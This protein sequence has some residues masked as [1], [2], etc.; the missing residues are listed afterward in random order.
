[1]VRSRYLACAVAALAVALTVAACGGGSDSTSSTTASAATSTDTSTS[2]ATT[3]EPTAYLA[4]KIA[5]APGGGGVSVA[6]IAA[7]GAADRAGV[8]P[9][10]VIVAMDG[11]TTKTV[12]ALV[13]QLGKRKPGDMVELTIERGNKRLKVT[14]TLDERPATVP[15]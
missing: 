2:T 6:A 11:T 8:R 5:T 12:N 7:G 10:D 9:G 4:A 14:A 3:Q 15:N 13:A 1:M